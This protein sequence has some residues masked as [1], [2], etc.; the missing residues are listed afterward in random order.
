MP[1][2]VVGFVVIRVNNAKTL[3]FFVLYGIS[4]EFI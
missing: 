4:V 3:S 2:N 1:F